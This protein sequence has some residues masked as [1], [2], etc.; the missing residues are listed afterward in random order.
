MGVR[1]LLKIVHLLRVRV[2]GA[3]DL[4][5]RLRG[6]GVDTLVIDASCWLHRAKLRGGFALACRGNTELAVA[7]FLKYFA[8]LAGL[9]VRCVFVFDGATP[10]LKRDTH[11]ARRVAARDCTERG[12]KLLANEG[13]NLGLRARLVGAALVLRGLEASVL[14]RD[15]EK[16]IAKVTNFSCEQ[17]A[18]EADAHLARLALEGAGRV[19]VV[20]EDSDL[21]VYGCPLVLFKFWAGGFSLFERA[22]R[23]QETIIFLGDDFALFCVLS[24]CD[25]FR[26]RGVGSAEALRV[27]SSAQVKRAF[28]QG[29]S[30]E[31]RLQVF[32]ALANF[33]FVDVNK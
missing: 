32:G 19:A 30:E 18:F 24:G 31:E 2:R 12:V 10:E 9:T 25:Y 22:S 20:T 29:L 5:S 26:R 15:V 11:A 23:E 17:A 3:E 1:N 16:A 28:L 8:V 14:Q 33:G 6:L 21:I 4:E 7:S 13:G 27:C